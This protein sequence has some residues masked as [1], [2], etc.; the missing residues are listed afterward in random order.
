[1]KIRTALGLFVVAAL[2]GPAGCAP[3]STPSSEPLTEDAVV[4][5]E[6]V[7]GTLP[8]GTQLK[9]TGNVNLRSG[10]STTAS[11]L[12]VVP[13]GSTVTV[14]SS[15]PSNGFYKIKHNGSV[16]WSSGKYYE[17]AG[18]PPDGTLEPGATLTATGDVNLRG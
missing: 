18:T 7:T 14:E 12:H 2:A 3:A 15:T 10:A 5:G 13:A 6:G 1:M 17:P 9:A 8:V 16:G 4:E 11:I